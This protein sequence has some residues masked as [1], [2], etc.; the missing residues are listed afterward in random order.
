MP[1]VGDQVLV[2]FEGG[3]VSRPCVL[4][5]LWGENARPPEAMDETRQNLRR[6]LRSPN[7]VQIVFD[8]QSGEEQLLI[9]T[10]GG[11]A[12]KLRCGPGR[13]EINDSNRNAIILEAGGIIL[14][15]DTRVA[16]NGPAV[17]LNASSLTVNAG[18]AKF[19]GVVQCDTLIANSVVANSYTP[20]A[21][22]IC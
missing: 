12:V 10:P 7:G 4:G 13:V 6:I 15:S 19:S 14:N 8:D 21:G 22:N 2:S 20:G 1:N 9:E 11:P 17:E 18:M 16:I 5:A 3:D